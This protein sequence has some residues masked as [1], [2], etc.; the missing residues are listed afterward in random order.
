MT[1]GVDLFYRHWKALGEVRRVVVCIH[2]IGE[3]SGFFRIIGQNL[4]SDDGAEVYAID[5]RGFGNSKEEGLPIGDT[6][7]F[8]KYLQD[9][10]E[11]VAY[12]RKNHPGKKLFMFGHS[13]GGL[14]A[15]WYAANDP[16]SPDGL[17]LAGSSIARH[18]SIGKVSV[19]E[20]PFL[21]SSSFGLPSSFSSLE[22]PCLTYTSLLPMNSRKAKSSKIMRNS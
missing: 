21:V 10:A 6:S 15:L 17:I 22:R 1:D 2:G 7:D 4:A 19:K 12:I 9:V 14:H 20:L 8:K 16:N 18:S 13:M 3:H 5:L 11:V